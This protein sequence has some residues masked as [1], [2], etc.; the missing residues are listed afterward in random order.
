MGTATLFRNDH[1]GDTGLSRV[2]SCVVLISINEKHNVRM[3]LDGFRIEKVTHH[4][5]LVRTIFHFPRQ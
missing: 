5:A 3:V 4:G 2:F 1:F